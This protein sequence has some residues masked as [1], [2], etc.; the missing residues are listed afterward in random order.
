[1]R[2]IGI[3]IAMVA[4]AAIQ[5][6]PAQAATEVIR[7]PANNTFVD[8]VWTDPSPLGFSIAEVT[9]PTAYFPEASSINFSRSVKYG[10]GVLRAALDHRL[11]RFGVP[12]P[13]Y[14]RADGRRLGSAE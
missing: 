4:A 3:A 12:A 2:K 5:V 8:A 10:F 1:M 11:T 13:S 14:L 7:L 9:C 6:S